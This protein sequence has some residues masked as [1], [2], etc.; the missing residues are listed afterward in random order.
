MET[1]NKKEETKPIANLTSRPPSAIAETFAGDM[2]EAIGSDAGSSI[3]KIIHGAEESEAE[4]KNLSPESKKNK[5]FMFVSFLLLVFALAISS[6]LL[7]RKDANTV[8]VPKQFVPLIFTD[9]SVSLEISGL[10]KNEIAQAVLGEISNATIEPGEVE[11]IYLTE[12][13]QTIGLRRFIAL[14]ESHFVPDSNPL[15]V[16]DNFLMGVV[17]NQAN[18]TTNSGTGFFILLKVGSAT[19][20]FDSLRAW[21]PNLLTDLHGFLG[22]N[23]NGANNYLFTKNFADG[24]VENK[25]ARILSDQNG[26]VVVMYI[27]A[28]DNSVVITDSQNTADQIILRL[29]SIQTSS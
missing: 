15:L 1:D 7:F 6:F 2:A 9:K 18:T 28:D 4:K 21:E 8:P 12:N 11:G 23:I 25:N 20:I 17:K 27:Y 13:K 26:N 10:K 22:I 19:D 3:R 24:L 14:T 16:S 29:A 5:I